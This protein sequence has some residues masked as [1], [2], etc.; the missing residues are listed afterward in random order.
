M[1]TLKAAERVA[2]LHETNH[3]A[4]LLAPS[5]VPDDH[6]DGHAKVQSAI[7]RVLPSHGWL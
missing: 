5:Y 2:T 7:V 6:A 1:N 3:T 4:V